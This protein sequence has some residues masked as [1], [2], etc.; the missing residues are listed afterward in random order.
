MGARNTMN[1]VMETYGDAVT[2]PDLQYD[3][4]LYNMYTDVA[5]T[6]MPKDGEYIAIEDATNIDEQLAQFNPE[7]VKQIKSRFEAGAN[8]AK[9]GNNIIINDTAIKQKIAFSLTSADGRYSAVAPLEELFHIYN[10]N[11]N[12]VN[13]QGELSKE[14]T[15]AVDEAIQILNNK[16]DVIFLL[17]GSSS[18]K[19]EYL[20]DRKVNYVLKSSHPSPLSSYRGFFG[21]RHFSK[22]NNILLNINK[23]PIKW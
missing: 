22:T 6:L 21:C 2:N 9:L 5:M 12:V 18:A 8:A 17:W 11:N 15:Q 13:E 10:K 23:S 20:I 19:K 1:E 3:F 14:A 4:G 16:R 7:V